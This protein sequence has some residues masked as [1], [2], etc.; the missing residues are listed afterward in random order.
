VA[1]AEATVAEAEAE[2]AAAQRE[3]D[4]YTTFRSPRD[5]G[6]GGADGFTG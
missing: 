3:A 6:A 5:G 2:A 4:G 1:H